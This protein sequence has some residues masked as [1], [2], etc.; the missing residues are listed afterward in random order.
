MNRI[1]L[2]IPG[3]FL[4]L[5]FG[6]CSQERT[7]SEGGVEKL[8]LRFEQAFVIGDTT[9]QADTLRIPSP[10]EIV[11]GPGGRIHIADSK[12]NTIQVYDQNGQFLHSIGGPGSGPGEFESISAMNI[13]SRGELVVA[14]APAAR[15]SFFSREGSLITELA[16]SQED[17]IWPAQMEFV[18]GNRFLILNK[19]YPNARPEPSVQQ[20]YLH[21]YSA[22]YDQRL[23]SFAPVESVLQRNIPYMLHATRTF[24]RGHMVSDGNRTAWYV[25]GIYEGRILQYAESDTGWSWKRTLRGRLSADEAIEADS[26]SEYAGSISRY[27]EE[28]MKTYTAYVKSHSLGLFR[29]DDGRLV[30]FSSQVADTVRRLQ[31]EVFDKQGRLQGI[32]TLPRFRL[33]LSENNAPLTFAWMDDRRR[34]YVIDEREVPVVRVGTVVGL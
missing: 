30:H 11:T 33:S 31:V 26:D 29:L 18:S 16:P 25:P 6:G 10:G 13:N 19:L 14:D 7:A 17:L 20:A 9:M 22:R 24:H 23:Q 34:F 27:D 8:D 21:L 15:I 32:G 3:L 5:L 12:L 28:G 4:L 2:V 1:S